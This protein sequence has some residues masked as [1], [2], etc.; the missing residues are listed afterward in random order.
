LFSF[1]QLYYEQLVKV[2]NPLYQN[3]EVPKKIRLFFFEINLNE[4]MIN[5]DLFPTVRLSTELY[6]VDFE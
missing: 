6:T 3:Y 2:N 1:L 4:R 5:S